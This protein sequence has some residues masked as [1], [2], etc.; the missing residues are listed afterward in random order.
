M[1][2]GLKKRPTTLGNAFHKAFS[3]AWAIRAIWQRARRR[4]RAGGTR[5][6]EVLSSGAK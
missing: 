1:K 4:L 2:V 5:G 6:G 3:T